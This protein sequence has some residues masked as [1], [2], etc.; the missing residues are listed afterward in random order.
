MID[1]SEYKTWPKFKGSKTVRPANVSIDYTAEQA[2]ELMKCINDVTYFCETYLKIRTLDHGIQKFNLRPYQKTAIEL[3]AKD[4]LVIM[5]WGRQ[6]FALDTPIHTTKGLKTIENVKV[7]DIVYGSSNQRVRVISLSPVYE[8]SNTYEISFSN[9]ESIV[10]D[11]DHIWEV[12]ESITDT[13]TIFEEFQNNSVLTVYCFDANF[14]TKLLITNVKR[15]ERRLVKCVETDAPDG[16]CL[17]G[18]TKIVSSNSGK[19]TTTA[20]ALVWL[21]LFNSQYEIGVLAHKEK[22]AKEILKRIKLYYELLPYWMQAGITIWNATSFETEAGSKVFAAASSPDSIRGSSLNCISGNSE[23]TLRDIETGEVFKTNVRYIRDNK[24]EVLTQDGF[25]SFDGIS[26]SINQ[27]YKITTKS[28]SISATDDHMF[29]VKSGWKKLKDLNVGDYVVCESGLEQITDI[30]KDVQEEVYDLLNVKD[31]NSFYANGFLVHNCVFMDEFAILGEELAEELFTSTFPTISSGTN[32][33][34]II[35]SCVTADT[36]V[37]TDQGI[38]TV[39]DFVDHSKPTIPNLGYNVEQYKV[40]GFRDDLNI[41]NTIV[42]N[43]LSKTRKI[44]TTHSELE[45]SLNHKLYCYDA[46][47][48]SYSWKTAETITFDDRIA[49]KYG[50][51]VWGDIYTHD[52]SNDKLSSRGFNVFKYDGIITSDIAYLLGQFIGDGSAY[53]DRSSITI[54]SED[55]ISFVFENLGLRCIKSKTTV[56]HRCNST[57][58]IDF[59]KSLGFDFNLKSKNK[60]IPPKLLTWTDELLASLLAGLFDADGSVSKTLPRT[61]Y[62][63]TSETLIDQIRVI[64]LNFGVLSYKNKIITPPNSL[65]SAESH[66]FILEIAGQYHNLFHDIVQMKITRK[67][68]R[69]IP[70]ETTRKGSS[71]DLIKDGRQLMINSGVI[72]D[73]GNFR[74]QDLSRRSV[75]DQDVLG[76]LRNIAAP[77]IV[78]DS[79]IDIEEGEAEVY[80]FSLDHIEGDRWCHSVLYNGIVG[81]QTPKG[82]NKFWK[83]W[84]EAE[85]GINGFTPFAIEYWDVPGR[86]EEWAKAEIARIGQAKFDQEYSASFIGSSNTL[87]DSKKLLSMAIRLPVMMDPAENLHIFELPKPNSQYIMTVDCSEGVGGDASTFTIFNVDALPY[88]VV[89]TYSNDMIQPMMYPNVIFDVAQYFNNAYVVIESNTIG[90]EVANILFYELEYENVL[91]S[92]VNSKRGDLDESPRSYLGVKTTKKTKHLGCSNLKSLIENDQLEV[93][94]YRTLYELARFVKKRG[95]FAAEANEHDDLVMNMVLFAWLTTQNSFK[96]LT[97][98]DVRVAMNQKFLNEQQDHMP[99][100]IVVQNGLNDPEPVMS[101]SEFDEWLLN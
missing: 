63:S 37:F 22:Q 51:N 59:I 13:K 97:N 70:F 7:G 20:A 48:N 64:L 47:S 32:S 92:N 29:A 76:K 39:G 95:S 87:I 89:A 96:D 11:E 55:D 61:T 98:T 12:N 50:M 75:V 28:R 73:H 5:K 67:R 69:F 34:F 27:T 18:K 2:L 86:D 43:G 101:L 66:G 60:V 74:Y 35:C 72:F 94:C 80:D 9:G 93:N 26:A 17:I 46:A 81:H 68:D 25:K 14:K 1:D 3:I 24:Y 99:R 31:T 30:Q 16:M 4:K 78:W 52:W 45:C 85:E 40:A 83:I 23:V 84:T 57:T 38:K 42:N 100:G 33:K 15:I 71:Q 56:S 10:C 53:Y 62:V 91:S 36:I 6:P 44:R 19:T 77:N 21:V 49:V 65:I 58:L 54:S 79:I 41:G 82:M 88:R 8:D 90:A